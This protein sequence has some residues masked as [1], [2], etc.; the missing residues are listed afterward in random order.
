MAKITLGS[1]TVKSYGWKMA[2]EHLRDWFILVL[3]C[4]IDIVLNSIEPFHRYIGPDMTSITLGPAPRLC[5]P[6]K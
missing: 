2:R 3:L 5:C 6:G 1:H 4:L